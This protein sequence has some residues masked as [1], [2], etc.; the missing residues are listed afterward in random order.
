[1]KVP[2]SWLQ[3]LVEI[4]LPIQ[5]LS[6]SLSIAGFE[7]ESLEDYS[8]RA[9]NVVVGYVSDIQKHPRAD[10][11]NICEVEI[12][13]NNT[14]QIVCGAS[15]IRK[16][17]HV[18]VAK[19]GAQLSA[20]EICIKS[21]ELRGVK[22]EGMIC[23][24]NE[25][26]IEEESKGIA[27]LEEMNIKF[28]K[29]GTS[30]VELLN[31]DELVI[32]LAITANRPDGMS[33]T[34][35]AREVSALTESKLNL[36]N[37]KD[38]T[39]L[40]LFQPQNIDEQALK[41]TDIYSLTIIE[42]V[43]GKIQ[44]NDIIKN[45]LKYSGIKSINA[46]VDLTNYIMLEQGQPLHAFDLDSLRVITAKEVNQESFGIRKAQKNETLKTLDGKEHTLNSNITVITCNDVVVAIAGLIGGYESSVTEKTNKIIVEAA[47]FTPSS[48]RLSSRNIGIRTESSSRFEKGI[49]SR[50]T[51]NSLKRYIDLLS[52][53][54][55]LNISDIFINRNIQNNVSPILLRRSR[56]DN[57]LGCLNDTRDSILK[58]KDNN[59]CSSILENYISDKEIETKLNL[60]GCTTNKQKDNWFV[61]VPIYRT[62]DLIRE[63]DLIEEIARLIGYDRFQA[64]L[65]EPIEPGGLN[66]SQLA[67]RKLRKCLS[68]A[69]FQEITSFSLVPYSEED[70][71]R[72]AI[73]NPLL[74]DTSHLRTNLLDEHLNIC[75][76]NIKAGKTGCWI[77][78]IGSV[79]KKKGKGINEKKMLAGAITGEKRFEKWSTNGKT[80]ELNYYQARG[81]LHE[82]L[83]GLKLKVTDKPLTEDKVLH[84]GRAA[85]IYLEGKLIGKFGQLHPLIKQE[86]G[87]QQAT[88]VF[89]LDMDLILQASIR[90]NLICPSFKQFP[91]VPTMER[92]IA[93]IVNKECTSSEITSLI[94]K[95]GKPLLEDV[96]LVDRYQGENLEENKVS[97]A[98]RIT[99]R[100]TNKTLTEND[101]N[102]I[103]EKIRNA[104]VNNL[105]AKLR[106]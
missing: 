89:E 39:K 37:L 24:L 58:G 46:I 3:E 61:E 94:R 104:L 80:I 42:N 11:L 103:H 50:N 70:K 69:G 88:Y 27:I 74:T 105:N 41:D 36:P 38:G 81:Y 66:E 101:I 91:T 15:N 82:A 73:S 92:D 75:N 8:K 18:L 26:G 71:E 90:K 102:P 106:S 12:G 79:Y 72:V 96:E 2:F 43:N 59:E 21:T 98:F 30:V 22:S 17:I 87:L 34:G 51:I 20:K 67:E 9:D 1:M 83:T 76:R 62:L 7:V 40:S 44:S 13:E 19:V 14:K 48:V 16:G 85:E 86:Y 78:E 64:N 77:F 23:S 52:N 45:R 32:D 99:Y 56:I 68:G 55:K 95:E 100:D 54:F 47:T 57:V 53:I 31:L 6:E 93:L 63:I 4:D 97:Q 84:P 10:K 49:S 65:P 33:I 29:P 25:L 35:I 28:P 60:L 5:E